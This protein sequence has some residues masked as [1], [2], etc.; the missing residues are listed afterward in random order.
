MRTNAGPARILYCESSA[1]GTIGGSHY[2]LLY[3]V[4][5]LDRAQYEPM[6]VF[7]ETHPLLP[8]F[9]AAAKTIVHPQDSPVVWGGTN[10]FTRLLRRGVNFLKFLG[11]VVR[12]VAF[13]RRHRVALV[14]LNNSITRHQDWMLAASLAGVPCVVHERGLN[15][16]YTARDRAY[17]RRVSLIIPMSAWI[18]DHMVE[19][20]VPGDNIRIMYDGLDPEKVK[21]TTDA[22][23]LREQWNVCTSARVVGI[24]G[25]IRAWKGQETVVR[26]VIEVAKHHPDVVCFFVGAAT[27]GDDAYLTNLQAMV[28]EAGIE[29]NVRF[30]GYQKEVP[31]L[32]NLM[33]FVI[34]A[35]VAPEP[36]GMVVL[37][38]MAQR[39]A[40]I[41]SRA[42]GPVEMIVEGETGLTFPPGDAQTLAAR[43]GELLADPER[44]RRMGEA[45]YKRL[46]QEFTMA[47]YMDEIHA[48]YK[49]ILARK[50]VPAEIGLRAVSRAPAGRHA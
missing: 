35:S 7:Y 46:L 3:L 34:H 17:A 12:H 20:G 8:R 23:R 47:K 9:Q 44:S 30:T 15:T 39:K 16:E 32:M 38:A 2:C 26:A 18:R 19:R 27:R 21:V 22:T 50:P 13:L 4:E 43:M 29:R 14:H 48:A 49:A 36:F 41:G 10:G 25:N 40:V 11:T 1:D 5:H 6:V 37:E 42:G 24:V 45:G 33:E 31:S 28:A